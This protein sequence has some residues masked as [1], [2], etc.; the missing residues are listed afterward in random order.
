MIKIY[1]YI[2]YNRR[3]RDFRS[4]DT[5]F[6]I[7]WIERTWKWVASIL[8]IIRTTRKLEKCKEFYHF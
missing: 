2:I 1:R 6:I 5:F 3:A 8:N 4:E 7:S